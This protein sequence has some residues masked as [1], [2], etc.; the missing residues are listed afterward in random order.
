M[1]EVDGNGRAKAMPRRF[2]SLVALIGL[3]LHPVD[4]GAQQRA[5]IAYASI[6]PNFAGLWVAKEAGAFEK[7]GL[8]AD[9]VYI[10]SGSVTV[11]AMMGGD[12]HLAI[13]ASNAVV[14]AILRGAPL[15][16]VGSVAN[17]PGMVLWVQ[18][19][20]NKPEQLQG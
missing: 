17:R 18:P 13:G 8:P 12:V 10:A 5:K 9:L 11:Q 14:N 16:A 19:E 2:L 3:F 15:V 7:H 4:L 6:S 1:V 20:I